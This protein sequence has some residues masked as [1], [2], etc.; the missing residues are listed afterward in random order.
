MYRIINGSPD[1][2]ESVKKLNLISQALSSFSLHVSQMFPSGS[3]P[4]HTEHR[5][6]GSR[7]SSSLRLFMSCSVSAIPARSIILHVI[8]T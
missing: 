6:I 3:L 1:K 7:F 5:F 4:M 8:S 2:P